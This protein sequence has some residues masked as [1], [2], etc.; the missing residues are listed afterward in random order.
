MTCPACNGSARDSVNSSGLLTRCDDPWHDRAAADAQGDPDNPPL[1]RHWLA[2][3]DSSASLARPDDF[4]TESAEPRPQPPPSHS[5]AA[6]TAGGAIIPPYTTPVPEPTANGANGF[7]WCHSC[8]SV[9]DVAG[10]ECVLPGT[11][12]DMH[13]VGTCLE[14]AARA[15]FAESLLCAMAFDHGHERLHV[16]YF[17][18]DIRAFHFCPVGECIFC[19]AA[20]K[21]GR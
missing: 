6:K 15:E 19:D 21:G 9:A 3:A 10:H 18:L 8:E 13:H 12:E 11:D 7:R 14:D 4:A 20:R 5:G 1:P 17:W 2:D 16:G